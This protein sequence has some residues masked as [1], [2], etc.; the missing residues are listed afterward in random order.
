M[1]VDH[2]GIVQYGMLKA[3]VELGLDY[4]SLFGTSV[5][6]LNAALLH[7]NDLE[8]LEYIWLSITTSKVYKWR[9]ALMGKRPS[10]YDSSP[11]LKLIKQSVDYNEILKNHKDFYIS[12]T[13]YFA[14]EAYVL[15]SKSMG[16]DAFHRFIYASASPPMLFPPVDIGDRTFIDGGL[17]S[18][19][20]I[21]EAIVN[22]D[23]ETVVLMSPTAKGRRKEISSILDL[24]ADTISIPLYTQLKEEQ[25]CV[26]KINDIIDDVNEDHRVSCRKIKIINCI[27]DKQFDFGFLDFDH[28][29]YDKKQLIAYGYEFAKRVLYEELS[30]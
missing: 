22:E 17:T 27:V 20:N 16:I 19:F 13:D 23:V 2:G 26:N 7:A 18:N 21:K 25:G 4:A 24:V 10:L 14:Q 11:L 9:Y 15:E 12:T 28:K 6:S 8:K 1:A 5:G 30:K 29:G 3:F